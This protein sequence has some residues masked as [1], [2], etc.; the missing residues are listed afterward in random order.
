ME[1]IYCNHCKTITY[2]V[3]ETCGLRC[4]KC[5]GQN[6]FITKVVENNIQPKEIE[7]YFK[8]KKQTEEWVYTHLD[9]KPDGAITLSGRQV[10]TMLIDYAI[11]VHLTKGSLEEEFRK[12]FFTEK[13]VNTVSVLIWLKN[14]GLL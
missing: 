4:Q 9:C 6:E 2:Q 5:L 8:H 13:E 10:I 1:L 11:G 14:K 12:K 3:E 7:K